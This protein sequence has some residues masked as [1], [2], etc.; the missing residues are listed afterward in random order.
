M[1][2]EKPRNVGSAVCDEVLEMRSKL[3]ALRKGIL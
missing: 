2:E 1:A 3:M